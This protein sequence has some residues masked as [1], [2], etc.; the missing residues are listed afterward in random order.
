MLNPLIADL[1]FVKSSIFKK[2]SVMKRSS[3]HTV[4][5]QFCSMLRAS[6]FFVVLWDAGKQSFNAVRV[7]TETTKA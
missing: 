7:K 5:V 1:V 4:L 2:S 6:S 3:D